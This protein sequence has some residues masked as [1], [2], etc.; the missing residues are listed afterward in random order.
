MW[1]A[2]RGSPLAAHAVGLVRAGQ[3][4]GVHPVFLVSVSWAETQAATDPNA[5][6]DITERHNPFGYGPHISFGSWEEGFER[7][8]SD[9]R[10]NYLNL[11]RRTVVQIRDRWAPLGAAN[12]PKGLNPGWARNVRHVMAELGADPDGPVGPARVPWQSRS[13]LPRRYPWLPRIRPREE[14]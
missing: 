10:R 7:V 5:G 14:T 9:L 8:A 13:W 1:L 11:G 2:E 12:D 3:R 4:W 6:K